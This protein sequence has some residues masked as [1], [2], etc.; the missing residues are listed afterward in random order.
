MWKDTFSLERILD[1]VFTYLNCI[2]FKLKETQFSEETTTRSGLSHTKRNIL[3]LKFSHK[4]G[5]KLLTIGALMFFTC[6][7]EHATNFTAG[8]V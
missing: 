2:D 1:Y 4:Y 8:C 7:W 5:G 3:I 6:V